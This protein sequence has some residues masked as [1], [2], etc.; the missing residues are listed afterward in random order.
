MRCNIAIEGLNLENRVK[1][2]RQLRGWTQE[3]LAEKS[4]VG[5]STISN[6]EQGKYIPGVDIALRLAKAMDCHVENLFNLKGED[7]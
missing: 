6:I 4:K 7:I 1:L 2:Q 5:R 3:K